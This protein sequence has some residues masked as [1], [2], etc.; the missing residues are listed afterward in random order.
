MPGPVPQVLLLNIRQFPPPSQQPAGQVVGL[1]AQAPPLHPPVVPRAASQSTHTPS[2]VPQKRPFVGPS[3]WQVSVASQ[4]P[5][6]LLHCTHALLLQRSFSGP[7]SMQSASTEPS[8]QCEL[9]IAPAPRHTDVAPL[10]VEQHPPAQV[11][12]L[13]V[14]MPLTH[15]SL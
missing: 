3:A 12:E 10:G 5:A 7:Q 6:P 13:Q 4:Q 14:H 2:L 8:L 1:H 15:W 9:S 11:V